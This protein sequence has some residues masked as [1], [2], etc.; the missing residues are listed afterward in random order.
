MLND[1]II[2]ILG[3]KSLNFLYR[4]GPTLSCPLHHTYI[5]L[6]TLKICSYTSKKINKVVLIYNFLLLTH[7]IINQS[8]SPGTTAWLNIQL[9]VKPIINPLWFISNTVRSKQ[10][11][12]P[13]T[14]INCFHCNTC[15][16]TL[17]LIRIKIPYSHST[18][19]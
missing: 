18:C 2:R 10:N 14:S 19:F 11:L 16:F 1:N 17:P 13:F 15:T 3:W 7:P 5:L 12:A 6:F 8:N 4:A 9:R